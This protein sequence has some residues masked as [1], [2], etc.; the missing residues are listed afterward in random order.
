VG[1][2]KISKLEL[3][4]KTIATSR[5]QESC[6][7]IKTVSD[8]Y[9]YLDTPSQISGSGPDLCHLSADIDGVWHMIIFRYFCLRGDPYVKIEHHVPQARI[10][11]P[12]IKDQETG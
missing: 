6:K 4:S 1:R 8:F 2:F 11:S 9:F 7:L 5:N 10:Y 3:A 12:G